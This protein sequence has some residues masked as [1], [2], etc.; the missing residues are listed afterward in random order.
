MG[1]IRELKLLRDGYL[2]EIF[3][4]GGEEVFTVLL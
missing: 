4:N 3:I 2:L 1:E